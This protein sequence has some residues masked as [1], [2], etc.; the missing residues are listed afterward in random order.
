MDKK[1]ILIVEDNARLR[2]YMQSVLTKEG[3]RVIEAAD[4]KAAYGCLRGEFL[5]LVLLDLRLGEAD[6]IEILRTIRRQDEDL[7]VIIVSSIADRD[8]KVTGFE[9]GCDDYITK[10]FYSEELLGRINRLLKRVRPRMEGERI[11]EGRVFSG[12][13]ELDI[14]SLIVTKNGTKIEMRKKL[15]DLFLFF[16]RHPDSVI[17]KET[18]FD[19]AWSSIEK[20]NEN[21]LYVHIRELR[22]LIEEEPSKPAFIT[23][24]RNVGFMYSPKG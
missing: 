7:P 9:L 4:E 5:D 18:L 6:G 20:M 21:N 23:T 14:E 16:V 10:P 19:R 22:I 13:F 17:S 8:V 12:P 24:V 1:S 15:F 11:L 3:Y 2:R